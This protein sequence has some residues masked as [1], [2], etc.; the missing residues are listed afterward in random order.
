MP[1]GRR[2]EPETPSRSLYVYR[3]APKYDYYYLR[4]YHTANLIDRRTCVTR[5]CDGGEGAWYK[6][7]KLYT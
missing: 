5:G 2:S 7:Q 1:V 6:L 4:Y 3:A